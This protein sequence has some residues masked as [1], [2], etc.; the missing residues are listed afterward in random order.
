MRYKSK[1][2]QS[3]EKKRSALLGDRTLDKDMEKVE[4]QWSPYLPAIGDDA[5]EAEEYEEEEEDAEGPTFSIE[6]EGHGEEDF[7]RWWIQEQEKLNEFDI[8]GL[9]N[10]INS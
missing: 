3:L 10:E 1:Q 7:M 9:L 6:D 8:D 4:T 5:L 2:P